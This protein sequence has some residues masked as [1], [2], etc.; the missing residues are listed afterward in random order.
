MSILQRTQFGD[1]ILRK[2]AKRVALKVINTP[3]FKTLIRDMFATI[4]DIGVGL[5]A[6]QIGQSI[7]LAV[8]DIHPLSHRPHVIPEKRV[9][10]N[11]KITRY[12]K[13]KELGYEGCLSCDGVRGQVPRAGEVVVEYCDEEGVKHQETVHGLLARVFQHEIDHLYGILY[14]DRMSD[15]RTLMT[16]QEYEKR[17]LKQ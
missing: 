13:N 3:V 12:S 8:I 2:K 14:V 15:M 6:P 11:P 16:V 7:Q 1:P 5:A 17:I 9:I 10:I 4:Q